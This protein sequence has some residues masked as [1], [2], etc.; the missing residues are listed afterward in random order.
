MNLGRRLAP[1]ADLPSGVLPGPVDANGMTLGRR[2]API[3]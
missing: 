1:E 3:E 2:L